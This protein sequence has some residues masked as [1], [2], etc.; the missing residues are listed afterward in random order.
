MSDKASRHEAKFDKQAQAGGFLAIIYKGGDNQGHYGDSSAVGTSADA[1]DAR[2]DPRIEAKSKCTTLGLE[3]DLAQGEKLKVRL[4]LSGDHEEHFHNRFQHDEAFNSRQLGST[5]TAIRGRGLI[6]HSQILQTAI[7]SR[8][9]IQTSRRQ[10]TSFF[11]R[12]PS[13]RGCWIIP[14]K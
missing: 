8:R 5:S 1:A 12:I 11:K 13:H 4:Q 6:W 7:L 9:M 2:Y 10:P 3:L 14:R